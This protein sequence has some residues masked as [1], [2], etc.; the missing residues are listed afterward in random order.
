MGEV[1][2]AMS[3]HLLKTAEAPMPAIPS[4]TPPAVS[5]DIAYDVDGPLPIVSFSLSSHRRLRAAGS[6][7]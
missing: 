3:T 2:T 5:S 6:E 4:R 7:P 1:D